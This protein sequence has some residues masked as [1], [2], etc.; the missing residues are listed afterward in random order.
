MTQM[1]DL[2]TLTTLKLRHEEARAAQL[3][4]EV[5]TMKGRVARID[6]M[7]AR[8]FDIAQDGYAR[9]QLGADALWHA[10]LSK[11]RSQIM[12]A[13]A[14][15]RAQQ[16]AHRAELALA[17]GRNEATQALA[18]QDRLCQMRAD[19]KKTQDKLCNDVLMQTAVARLSWVG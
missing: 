14:S 10:H 5:D 6:A 9:Q 15:L 1:Q 12:S 8:A 3:A 4:S 7:M 16:E 2:V 13:L 17:F 19:K 11:E 18:T